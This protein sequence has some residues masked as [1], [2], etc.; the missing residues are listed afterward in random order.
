MLD[1]KLQ[2]LLF[3]LLGFY[4][5]LVWFFSCYVCIIILLEM[6]Y[7]F[8]DIIYWI[9]VTQLF[10][11]KGLQLKHSLESQTFVHEGLGTDT[12]TPSKSKISL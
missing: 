4:L 9:Y 1:M 8:F 2:N 6:E 11:Y 10:L 7:F 12:R 5:S 3:A